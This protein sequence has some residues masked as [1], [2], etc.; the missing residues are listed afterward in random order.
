[1]K[2]AQAVFYKQLRDTLKS[3][4]ILIQFIIFPLVAFVMSRLAVPNLDGVPC[5]IAEMLRANMPNMVTMMATIFAGMGLITVVPGIITED[6][7]KKSLR[8]LVMAGVKPWSY[9]IGI[10]G[11]IFLAGLGT[12]VAFG[13]IGGFRGLDFMIFT[14][15]M[16]SGVVASIVLGAMFGILAGTHQAA[17]GLVLP[18]ALI[19]GFGP[20]VAQF[21]D[22]AAR[23]LNI[24]YTQQL[25]VIADR[26]T[27]GDVGTPLWQSFAIMWANVAVLGVLFAW[28]FKKKWPVA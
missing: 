15:A 27:I 26:L 18:I 4:T 8:F 19:L 11:V 12:S 14:A 13:V 6:M 28:V 24:F 1:M 21:N 3:P 25:N 7:E 22:N 5:D 17:S 2:N 9:L 23:L 16:L 20:M 10:G